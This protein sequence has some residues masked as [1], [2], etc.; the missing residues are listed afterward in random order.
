MND[1]AAAFKDIIKAKDAEA[2]F[3][4]H[5]C[6]TQ[7]PAAPTVF[8]SLAENTTGTSYPGSSPSTLNPNDAP[9]QPPSQP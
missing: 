8:S 4:I 1:D 5:T 3:D 7:L 6:D 2:S 9:A